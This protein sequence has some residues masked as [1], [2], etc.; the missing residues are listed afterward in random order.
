MLDVRLA[1]IVNEVV[2]TDRLPIAL[3]IV[4][5]VI[6]RKRSDEVIYVANSQW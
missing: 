1:F 2:L 4:V 3:Y 6:V 5:F